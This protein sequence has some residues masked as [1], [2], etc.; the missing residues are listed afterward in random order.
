MA[1]HCEYDRN[2]K[3]L[4]KIKVE[5]KGHAEL[6][7]RALR[8]L[9]GPWGWAPGVLGVPWVSGSKSWQPGPITPHHTGAGGT[10][11]GPA[12]GTGHLHED[13][14]GWRLGQ[15]VGLRVGGQAPWWEPGSDSARS[16]YA[17][18]Q[19]TGTSENMQSWRKWQALQ[20][21]KLLLSELTK[22]TT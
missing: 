18:P 16:N 19:G 7:V 4:L 10:R 12:L 20:H 2:N 11:A 3:I 5:N 9:V 1:S 22:N 6:N 13:G 21:M 14:D 17:L 8:G 15:D